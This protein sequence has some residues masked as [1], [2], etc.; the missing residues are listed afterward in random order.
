MFDSLHEECGVFAVYSDRTTDVAMTAYIGLYALQHRGQESCGIV[1]NDRG[2]FS[3]HKDLGLVHEVFDKDTLA[4][5]GQ[6]NIAI[7]HVRYSTTGNSNR[8]NAQPLVVRH[9]KGPLAIAHNGNL[10]NARELREEYE[11]KG[12]IFHSTNDTEVI[13]YAITEQRL[14]Q[15]S[16]EEAVEKAVGRLRGAFSIVVMSPKKLIAARDPFGFRPLSLG[17]LGD[18]AYVVSSETCAFDSVGAEFIRDLLPG[19][20]IVID[21]DGVRSIKTY[22]GTEKSRFCVFEYVYFARPD[23][24]I[25]GASVHRARLRAGE[26]LWKEHPVDADVVIGVPD[27]GLDAALGLSRASGIPYGVGFI[28]NRYVGRT[29]IQPTQ[30]E[31]TN[32]VKI[33]LNVVNDTVKGKRVILVDDSIVRGTTSKRIVNLIR[34]AGAKEIHVRISCPP[35]T[36]PCFFGT[37]IDSKENLIACKMSVD[38]ICREI[39]ADSL[40]YLSVE[41]VNK[42]AGN[43]AK[44]GFCDACFTG[45]YPCDVPKEMPKDK[46]EFKI[47]N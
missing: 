18:G 25:E 31:R 24:V 23:S 17:K 34:E 9:M 28:K 47:E 7:G 35:F 29:F 36:N 40:G 16:I 38:E 33:K 2:V 43:E 20:I 39:G 19:E 15:P 45:N 42:I 1:V 44:C 37:D 27:S 14:K 4:S 8:S 30:A 46:F 41:G 21:G 13:S 10:V 22:C 26:F 6:G 32:S 11:L 5:L 3:H 12:A